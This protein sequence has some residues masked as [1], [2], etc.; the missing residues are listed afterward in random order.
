[1]APKINGDFQ[2]PPETREAICVRF[3]LP[4]H[5]LDHILE[6]SEHSPGQFFFDELSGFE[7]N[8]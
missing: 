2:N 4:E 7:K 5:R 1:M 3:K 6:I 8:Q